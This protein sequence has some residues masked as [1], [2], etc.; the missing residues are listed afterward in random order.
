MTGATDAGQRLVRHRLPDRLYH[1]LMAACVLA[2][3]LTGLLPVAGVKLAWVTPHWIVGLALTALVALHVV[4]SLVWLERDAMLI[5]P[6]DVRDGWRTARFVVGG[7][8]TSPPKPGKY[9]LAQKL[10][11]LA[12]AIVVLAAVATGLLMM[13]K[14]DTPWWKRDPYWLAD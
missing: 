13:V 12:A 3:L 9:T 8:R 11:H 1:W 14:I 4:R 6:R 2:L 7:V 10:Y 5:G